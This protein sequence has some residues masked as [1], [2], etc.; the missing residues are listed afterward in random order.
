MQAAK[1]PSSPEW[2]APCILRGDLQSTFVFK[3][4]DEVR[5][6]GLRQETER[7]VRQS[8]ARSHGNVESES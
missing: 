3:G 5:R 8:P 7:E 1:D 4:F 6:L 2:Q